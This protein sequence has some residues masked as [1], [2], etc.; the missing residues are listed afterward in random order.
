MTAAIAA[1][2]FRERPILFSAPMIK[3]ILS[4]AKTQ[5][6]RVI[7]KQPTRAFYCWSRPGV[8]LF[9]SEDEA[10][11]G[12]EGDEIRCPYG[13]PGDRL[14]VKETWQA[15]HQSRDFETGYV[16][17]IRAAPKIPKDSC[18]G[19]WMPA[20]AADDAWG[21]ESAD[22]RGFAWRPSIFM[23]RWASRITLEI[24]EVL[25]QRLQEIGEGDARAEGVDCHHHDVGADR[26]TYKASFRLLWDSING[27]P[28]PM[29]DD[30]GEPVIDDDG[31]PRMV[32]SRSWASNP[33]VWA[34]S[35]RRLP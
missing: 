7:A 5:T 20:Y 25:V 21:N 28:R 31:R 33:W 23:P 2:A 4:G 13:A 30:D 26:P 1:P 19:W 18:D 8:A 10:I 32:A 29:L 24:T 22:D 15:V 14:W 35:F 16:D 12:D 27:K 3:A 11:A 6:R 9:A 17:D 34:V